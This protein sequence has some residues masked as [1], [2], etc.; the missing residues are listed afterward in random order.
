MVAVPEEWS[1]YMFKDGIHFTT[2]KADTP[3]EIIKE[4]EKDNE[5][6]IRIMGEPFFHFEQP[7]GTII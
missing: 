5:T 1:N 6:A 2:F 7:D 3:K 4:A